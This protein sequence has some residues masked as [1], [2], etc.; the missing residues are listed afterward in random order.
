MNIPIT[1]SEGF[2][3]YQ[4]EY[5]GTKNINKAVTDKFYFPGL[6]GDRYYEP[7]VNKRCDKKERKEIYKNIYAAIGNKYPVECSMGD[8]NSFVTFLLSEGFTPKLKTMIIDD[9]HKEYSLRKSYKYAINKAVREGYSTRLTY[10]G[11]IEQ[12]QNYH[13]LVSGKKTRSDETWAI[14][15]ENLNNKN[16]IIVEIVKDYEMVGYAYFDLNEDEALYSVG[17]YDRNLESQKVNLGHVSLFYAREILRKL[18]L[19][20]L[21]LGE[22]HWTYTNMPDKEYSI[23]FFKEGFAND[24]EQRAVMT[25]ESR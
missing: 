5:H 18:G 10:G 12:Y 17:V 16:A 11:S 9:L 3:K 24:Y 25:Y 21:I 23:S 20:K 1:H 8:G 4:C 14:Q 19:R 6:V 2:V 22:R 15:E 13:R 7:I